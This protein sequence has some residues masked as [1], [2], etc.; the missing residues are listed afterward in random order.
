[1]GKFLKLYFKKIKRER[2]RE[3]ERKGKGGILICLEPWHVG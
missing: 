2:E 1:M 3:R